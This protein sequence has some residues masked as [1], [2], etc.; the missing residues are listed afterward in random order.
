MTMIVE[1]D[2]AYCH[3]AE[4]DQKLNTL[5]IYFAPQRPGQLKKPIIVFI[6]GGGWT[7]SDKS[8]GDDSPLPKWFVDQD[9]VFVSVNFRLPEHPGSP[10]A[11]VYEMV[12]DIGKAIKW[13]TVNGR[14]FGGKGDGFVLLGYSSGAHLATLLGTDATYLREYRLTPAVI[15]GVIALDV[16]HLDIPGAMAIIEAE[17]SSYLPQQK[18]RL[19]HLHKLFGTT[20]ADQGRYSPATY[21]HRGLC[22]TSFLLITTELI[23][24]HRQ[25]LSR[26]MAVSF[27]RQLK[28]FNIKAGHYHVQNLEHGQIIQCFNERI[29]V[30]VLPFLESIG[31]LPK[32]A[33]NVPI[34]MVG[35]AANNI[36]PEGKVSPQD[37][38]AKLLSEKAFRTARL[39]RLID[40][41]KPTM[42]LS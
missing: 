21:L 20:R 14:R 23:N 32:M 30:Y 33:A 27:L 22:H 7:G 24:G 39:K 2:I 17:P 16:P 41:A 15:D 4:Y 9:C 11:T 8:F 12:K 10:Q 13:L 5:D 1:K 18:Q 28:A 42:P 6:H 3:A 34:G 29:A 38:M 25:S 36:A 26:N 19:A 37:K 31:H 35:K 40:L